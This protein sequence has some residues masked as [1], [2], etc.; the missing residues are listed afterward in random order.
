MSGVVGDAV[1]DD[2]YYG[3]DDD[4]NDDNPSSL[5]GIID[6][7]SSLSDMMRKL[8]GLVAMGYD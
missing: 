6:K 7:M 8:E 3:N 2:Y 5:T 4:D 1:D